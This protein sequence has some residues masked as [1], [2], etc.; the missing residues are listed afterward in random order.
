MGE[1]KIDE[2]RHKSLG[3][4]ILPGYMGCKW[5]N[6]RRQY[7]ETIEIVNVCVLVFCWFFSGLYVGIFG[8]VYIFE[9]QKNN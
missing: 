2:Y 3:D 7:A 5:G 6:W 9:N 4:T 8:S 1:P